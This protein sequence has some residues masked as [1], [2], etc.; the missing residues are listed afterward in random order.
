MRSHVLGL[1]LGIFIVS[2]AMMNTGNDRK[3]YFDL[4]S[5]IIVLGGTLSVS[6][7]THGF[8]NTLKI[9]GL[10]FKVFTAQKYN[11]VGITRE[12]VDISKKHYYG[13]LKPQD[14]SDNHHPFILDGVKLLQNKF[15][16]EKM[17]TLMGSMVLERQEGHEKMVEKIEIIA[18]YPPAFG[19]MG[20]IIGLVAVLKQ[21]NSPDNMSTIGPSMAL[22]L[23]TTLY[24]ILLS[25]YVLQPIAD[26]LHIRSHRDIKIRQLIA[27]GIILMSQGHDPI[28]IREVLLSHLTPFERKHFLKDS[29]LS[30]MANEELAA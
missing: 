15:D 22:A 12:L 26:N 27:E 16:A 2:Y 29:N 14:I 17:Q 23:V 7:M 3:T 20:T 25:N 9:C 1:F 10:F 4:L 11:S 19:M 13:Q 28:Y 21:I 18:K 24:G 30:P 5:I 8:M 6:I